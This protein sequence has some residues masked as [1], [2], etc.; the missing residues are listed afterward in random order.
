M[1][2]I[3]SFIF[4]T[5]A[6]GVI[7]LLIL[8]TMPGLVRFRACPSCGYSREGLPS[9]ARCPECGREPQDSRVTQRRG[10]SSLCGFELLV[11]AGTTMLIAAAAGFAIVL[12]VTGALVVV[13]IPFVAIIASP[14]GF[15][16]GAVIVRSRR[17]WIA[18]A[19]ERRP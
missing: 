15:F 8:A 6:L 4:V 12:I 3:A 13:A 14:A 17:D 1:F 10:L 18:S 19:A 2:G 9:D 16:I 11:L 5:V 7:G